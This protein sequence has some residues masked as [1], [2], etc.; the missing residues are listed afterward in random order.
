MLTDSSDS[1]VRFAIGGEH[2]KDE[3]SPGMTGYAEEL[4]TIEQ[5]LLAIRDHLQEREARRQGQED[6]VYRRLNEKIMRAYLKEH[7]RLTAKAGYLMSV[8][9][10]I[11]GEKPAES[12]TGR[13]VTDTE[14]ERARQYPLE[15]LIESKRGMARC[16]SGT[17][18]DRI[19]SMQTTGNFCFCHTCGFRADV[20]AVYQKLH[21]VS[22]PNAVRAL[23]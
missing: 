8:I 23:I 4:A 14:I 22:F 18:E 9:S 16:I 10:E 6:G 21:G 1:L 12:R 11:V 2:K 7:D 3:V 5:M 20:I 17:H 13:G 19:A 15:N